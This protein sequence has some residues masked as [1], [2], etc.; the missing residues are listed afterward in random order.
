MPVF[1]RLRDDVVTITVD[2]DY[3]ANELR[4]VASAA[5]ESDD[6]P[7]RFPIL[8][9]MSGA[10]GVLSKSVE[11]MKAMGA[12]FGAHRNRISNLGVVAAADAHGMF[13][14]D[15]PFAEEAG[16]PVRAC[17]SH[18]DVRAWFGSEGTS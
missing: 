13:A 14:L 18:A 10:A 17:H 15:S 1:A 8:M 9:D 2:G 12:I 3:T 11:E 7:A 16:L 4:R 5:F 6:I